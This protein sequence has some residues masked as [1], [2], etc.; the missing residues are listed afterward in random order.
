MRLFTA[1]NPGRSSPELVRHSQVPENSRFP[2]QS[3][4]LGSKRDSQASTLSL[5]RSPE[6]EERSR[7]GGTTPPREHSPASLV[8]GV[9]TLGRKFSRRFEKFGES[10]TARKLRMASPSRKYQWALGGGYDSGGSTNNLSASVGDNQAQSTSPQAGHNHRDDDPGKKRVSRVDSFRNFLSL[11]SSTVSVSTLRTP[12]A[13]KRRS[14]NAD[15]KQKHGHQFVDVGTSTNGVPE[16]RA[17][18]SSSLPGGLNSR[19]GSDL[20]L[21]DT[22]SDL[23]L[24]EC[25]SEVDLRYYYMATEDEDDR[26]V[27]SD[28]FVRKPQAVSHASRSAG[29]LA[30]NARLGILPENRTINF[31]EAGIVYNSSNG[32]QIKSYGLIDG[33]SDSGKGSLGGSG[34]PGSYH[35]A[36]ANHSGSIVNESGYSS[37]YASGTNSTSS[38]ASPRGSL[39]EDPGSQEKT[40]SDDSRSLTPP[41]KEREERSRLEKITPATAPPLLMK[42]PKK[43]V[44]ISKMGS[45]KR[46]HSSDDQHQL[47]RDHP[48]QQ[49]LPLSLPSS[50]STQT[51]M[52]KDYKMIRLVKEPNTEL[53]IIIAKKKLKE[54]QTTG[55]QIVHIEP[56][57]LI[58][59]DGRFQVGDEI[60]NVNSQRLRGLDIT[61]AIQSLRQ[62]GPELSIVICRDVPHPTSNPRSPLSKSEDT[63]VISERRVREEHDRIAR[64][65]HDYENINP[66]E[67][68]NLRNSYRGG[69][70]EDY[71]SPKSSFVTRTYIGTGSSSTSSLAMKIH[72]KSLSRLA[73]NPGSL[74]SLVETSLNS[75]VDEVR[76]SCSAYQP[77][78]MRRDAEGDETRSNR[79]FQGHRSFS[80]QSGYVSDSMSWAAAR[81]VNAKN[82]PHQYSLHTVV[83]EKGPGRKGLGFSVVGGRDSPKGN[84]GIFVKTIFPNGQANDQASLRE[85]DEI[86]SVNG[87][88]TQGLSH[89]EAIAIF[90]GI[91]SG[92]V[93]VHIARR[94]PTIQSQT[95]VEPPKATTTSSSSTVANHNTNHNTSTSGR[96][97]YPGS[98]IAKLILWHLE[99][100]P[101]KCYLQDTVSYQTAWTWLLY[102]TDPSPRFFVIVQI[103][104]CFKWISQ[105]L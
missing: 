84:M 83:F 22:Q 3:S 8:R 33:K 2:S 89:S 44:R 26:S 41:L 66:E 91:R 92:K 69:G 7:G 78:R 45:T 37:D 29:N 14:R 17:G 73:S 56:E 95:T 103:F 43:P 34:P 35:K 97:L 13:V 75:D 100:N 102:H 15:K 79:S 11:A 57:G 53:G 18:G 5:Y 77:V 96:S 28:G 71:L 90:K 101:I 42:P 58:D 38:R 19:F 87:H 10:E 68:R 6:V 63:L 85:G 60:I 74:T 80:L 64:K 52:T 1:T 93:T 94:D 9:S 24:S 104:A 48:E 72:R 88:S 54:L 40:S 31:Q 49:S 51:K 4:H 55:F 16:S 36:I 105:V 50:T 99:E 61:Q 25:Q 20:T 98:D 46:S 23:A 30:H 59:R 65:L 62:P 39:D 67:A 82:S 27:V 86:L 81:R 32:M 70:S 12:R 47:G 76:S 21:L